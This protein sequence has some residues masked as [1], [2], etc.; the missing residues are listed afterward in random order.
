MAT[1][2]AQLTAWRDALRQARASGLRRLQH[3]DT[4]SEFK[5]DAE[6]ATALADLNR[7]IAAGGDTPRSR[8]VYIN[9]KKGT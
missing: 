6:M 7:Q 9:A 8:I 2:L 3:G 5:S 4:V 1:T